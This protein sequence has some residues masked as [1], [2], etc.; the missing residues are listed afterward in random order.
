TGAILQL[1]SDFS[2]RW[3]FTAAWNQTRGR[4]IN[5]DGAD[6]PL[7]HIAPN[8]GRAGVQY[9]G[10]RIRAE[11][12]SNFSGWKRLADYSPSGE[13]NLQYATA[14]GMP[15]WWTLN[16]RWSMEVSKSFTLQ[17]GIDN[18]FDLQYRTFASGI[19]APG[20][21]FFITGRLKF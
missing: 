11:L 17:T 7:D 9:T 15:S 13:D 21:N 14:K 6:T 16:L 3:N 8:F 10:S 1:R 19:N 20:R 4:V 18:M 5:K 2:E 12:F